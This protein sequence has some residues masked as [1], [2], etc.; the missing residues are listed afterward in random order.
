MSRKMNFFF[1]KSSYQGQ[2]TTTRNNKDNDR[3]R[4]EASYIVV[5]EFYLPKGV[6]EED[7]EDYYVKYDMARVTLKDG[8]RLDLDAY[9]SAAT[10]GYDFKHPSGTSIEEVPEDELPEFLDALEE[11]EEDNNESS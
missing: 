10:D 2:M 7:V 9:Y 5:S 8:T 6:R 4:I 11:K 3:V 1:P